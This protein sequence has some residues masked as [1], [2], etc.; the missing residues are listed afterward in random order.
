M[1]G[2]PKMV[3]ISYDKS[4]P[5]RKWPERVETYVYAGQEDAYVATLAKMVDVSNIKV[6]R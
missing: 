1:S 2:A 4:L 5:A 3:K 6:S